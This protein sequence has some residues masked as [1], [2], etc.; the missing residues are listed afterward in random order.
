MVKRLYRWPPIHKVADAI[1]PT[2][3][4]RDA[5]ARMPSH[6]VSTAR[7]AWA[8]AARGGKE[9]APA[10]ESVNGARRPQ[11]SGRVYRA[12]R[13]GRDT[14]RREDGL[15]RRRLLAGWRGRRR[16]SGI[17]GRTFPHA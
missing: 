10:V 7:R 11:R 5:L 9:L 8:Q 14:A 12:L 17:Q 4:L 13:G 2:G 16:L 15:S 1:S 3:P 6:R